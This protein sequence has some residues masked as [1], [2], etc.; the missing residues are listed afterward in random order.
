MSRQNRHQRKSQ[1]VAQA[2]ETRIIGQSNAGVSS[3]QIAAELGVGGRDVRRVLEREELIRQ[4]QPT[5]NASDL[6]LTDKEKLELAISQ[7]K[8]RLDIEFEQRVA[9]RT[10]TVTMP[11][12]TAVPRTKIGPL[13]EAI[14]NKSIIEAIRKWREDKHPSPEARA[15]MAIELA[16]PLVGT[17][18]SAMFERHTE[19]QRAA[20]N[21][22][23]LGT[24]SRSRRR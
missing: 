14:E 2:N 4:I 23:S 12:T 5:I 7:H 6:S 19:N 1:A 24:P 8:R 9:E 10:G 20:G 15:D 3:N 18:F 11:R 22:I 21:I 13:V 17:N 16:R